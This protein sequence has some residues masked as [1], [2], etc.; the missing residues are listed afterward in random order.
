VTLVVVTFSIFPFAAHAFQPA[1]TVPST[2]FFCK[3][4]DGIAV[5]IKKIYL[6]SLGF[7]ALVAFL[8]IVLAGYRYLTASGN[9]Q[10][11]EGAKDAFA[12]AFIGLIIIFVAF[13]LL[14]LIN[15]DLVKF[16]PLKLP[17]LPTHQ[18]TLGSF[19]PKV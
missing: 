19:L 6:F 18:S 9:A 7:G 17:D 11:V 3:S 13:I 1:Q 16:Q 15:P 5:C 10:Q 2:G 14:Y 8:M 12:S 4:D